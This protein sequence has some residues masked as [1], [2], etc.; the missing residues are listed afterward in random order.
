MPCN[1]LTTSITFIT[2]QPHTEYISTLEGDIAERD[3]LLDAI[4]SELG[5]TQSENLALRQEIA[6]LKKTLLDGR[7]VD[8]AP[9]LNLPPP[10]PLPAQSAAA[11]L[12][13]PTPTPALPTTTSSTLVTPNT[14]K[15]M[16]HSHSPRLGRGFWG[17]VGMGMGAGGVTPV[18]T[19]LMPELLLGATKGLGLKENINPALNAGSGVG[20]NGG[21]PVKQVGGFD[22]FADLNPFTM[23]TL[24][25]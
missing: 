22:G 7:G 19:A 23:K 12:A 24:D 17:G 21:S 11:T 9:M 1:K 5:S 10:A 14:H 15:D 13:A 6:T 16:P 20:G 8:E 4:R 18:H 2:P 3:R 25:A